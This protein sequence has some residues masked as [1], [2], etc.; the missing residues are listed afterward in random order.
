MLTPLLLKVP[1]QMRHRSVVMQ[2]H[3]VS[4]SP[5]LCPQVKHPVVLADTRKSKWTTYTDPPKDEVCV[6]VILSIITLLVMS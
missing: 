5:I 6:C 3:D 2:P 4:A 1:Q